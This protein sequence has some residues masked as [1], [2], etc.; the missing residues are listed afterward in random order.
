MIRYLIAIYILA[1]LLVSGMAKTD[2]GKKYF[3]IEK[4]YIENVFEIEKLK[5]AANKMLVAQI[6]ETR[7]AL[8]PNLSS[9]GFET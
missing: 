5:S 4:S 6:I 2:L 1:V 3:Q 9:L 7:V 8:P